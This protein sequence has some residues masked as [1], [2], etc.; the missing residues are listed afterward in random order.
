MI[1]CLDRE[2][3]KTKISDG[4]APEEIGSQF[5]DTPDLAG[6]TI[7]WLAAERKEWLGGKYVSCPWDMEELTNM[8]DE[9]VSEDKLK[10]R[11]VF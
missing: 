5:S 3:I 6:D 9:I 2:A 4:V 10:P 7:A 8:E 11:L 1:F